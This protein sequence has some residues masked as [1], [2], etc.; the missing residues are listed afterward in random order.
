MSKLTE[1]DMLM[2]EVTFI[3]DEF[4]DKKIQRSK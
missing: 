1:I 2:S 4:D 3:L